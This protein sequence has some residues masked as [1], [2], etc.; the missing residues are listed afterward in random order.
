MDHFYTPCYSTYLELL[1]YTTRCRIL[2]MHTVIQHSLCYKSSE[3]IGKQRIDKDD[4]T[5]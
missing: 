3:I 4:R 5:R 2:F 1:T